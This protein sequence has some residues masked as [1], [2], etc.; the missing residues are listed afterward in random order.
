LRLPAA[1]LAKSVARTNILTIPKDVIMFALSSFKKEAPYTLP[2][3]SQ[4]SSHRKS[5]LISLK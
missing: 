4:S 1:G 3:K 2:M 5:Q